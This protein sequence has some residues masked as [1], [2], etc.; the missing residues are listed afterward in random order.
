[1]A[2]GNTQLIQALE[3][4]GSRAGMLILQMQ[5]SIGYHLQP[6]AASLRVDCWWLH[7]SSHGDRACSS[8]LILSERKCCTTFAAATSC[9]LPRPVLPTPTSHGPPPPPLPFLA[10]AL[11]EGHGGPVERVH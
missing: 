6:R 1:M 8:L 7:A 11:P 9:R 10:A 3:V 5:H 2:S 4:R